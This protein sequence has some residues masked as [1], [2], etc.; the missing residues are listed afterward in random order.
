M[1]T[2]PTPQPR[3]AAIYTRLSKA[4]N[5]D[6]LACQR[7]EKECRKLAASLGWEVVR[8]YTDNDF[9][10]FTGKARPGHK[11]LLEALEAENVDALLAWDSDRLHRRPRDLERLIDIIE[12]RKLPVRTVTSGEIDLSTPSGRAM[13][14]TLV[15]WANYESEHKGERIRSALAQ[16]RERGKA[17]GG[18]RHYGYTAGWAPTIVPDEAEH[19]RH[20][21]DLLLRGASLNAAVRALEARGAVTVGNS[22]HPPR[23]FDR[24]GLKRVLLSPRLAGRRTYKGGLVGDGD[25]DPIF[26]PAE[27]LRLQALFQQGDEAKIG[28]RPSHLLTGIIV[29]GECGNA[30]HRN[31]GRVDRRRGQ[32]S[33]AVYAC[34]PA[35]GS[36]ACRRVSINQANSD[37][38][39]RR[40][41]IDQ[42]DAVR[43]Q[44][45]A[46]DDGVAELEAELSELDARAGSLGRDFADGLIG[47]DALIGGN[48]QLERRRRTLQ[49]QLNAHRGSS[50]A[51]AWTE[52][53]RDLRVLWPEAGASSESP[54]TLDDRRQLV[55]MVIRRISVRR[56]GKGIW[57]PAHERMD[58]DWAD[59]GFAGPTASPAVQ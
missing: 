31:R 54:L 2:A 29:C 30:M 45:V 25:W 27:H 59:S 34:M 16:A 42:L 24:R 48:A 33:G 57:I 28:R 4:R 32:L 7:Q 40:I 13:A 52:D 19:L 17:P 41:V 14:R 20:A 50:L 39:I 23:P 44:P 46:L 26:T 36:P 11:E 37:E 9:S 53:S 22:K 38:A 3:R 8:V 15:A 1:A 12:G 51:Q 43:H 56:V 35:P 47:R 10:A 21:K 55:K 6:T 49:Q 5:G 18:V 58:I